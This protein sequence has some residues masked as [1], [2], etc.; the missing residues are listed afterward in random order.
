MAGIHF[1]FIDF[2]Q[3]LALNMG[4]AD[5][6]DEN[7][8]ESFTLVYCSFEGLDQEVID[9]SLASILRTSDSIVN[10]GKDYFFVLPYTDKYGADIVKKQFDEAFAR[11]LKSFMLSYPADGENPA[12]LLGA[13]QDSVSF[14][15]KDD[16]HCLDRFAKV[17]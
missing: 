11:F 6:L 12:E 15:L 8:A 10:H 9:N 3:L 2:K 17:I 1:S 16:L 5:R 4:I 13:L 7:R 14:F